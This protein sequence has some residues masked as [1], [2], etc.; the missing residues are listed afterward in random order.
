[1]LSSR[2]NHVHVLRPGLLSFP[3]K[4]FLWSGADLRIID[5]SA[6]EMIAIVGDAK[7]LLPRPIGAANDPPWEE[8][9]KVLSFLPD[10]VIVIEHC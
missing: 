2:G 5:R 7:T 6:H 3:V 10:N 1:M 9:L 4:Q 8:V